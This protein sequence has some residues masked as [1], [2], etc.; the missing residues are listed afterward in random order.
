[1]L[2]ADPNNQKPLW[3]NVNTQTKL[4]GSAHIYLHS[5]WE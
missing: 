2:Y 4:A 5:M 3:S 1:M